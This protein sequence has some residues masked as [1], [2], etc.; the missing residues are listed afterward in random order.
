MIVPEK[1]ILLTSNIYEDMRSKAVEEFINGKVF[2]YHIINVDEKQISNTTLTNW[3]YTIVKYG[4]KHN[5]NFMDNVDKINKLHI[6]KQ[7]KLNIRN[8]RAQKSSGRYKK[9]NNL[10]RRFNAKAIFCFNTT[11]LYL[12]VKARE[13]FNFDTK[14]VAYFDTFTFDKNA[15]V[16]NADKYV[17]ENQSFKDE[18]I[19]R[20]INACDIEVIKFPVPQ[21]INITESM[22]E[23]KD[24]FE[25]DDKPAIMVYGGS[26]GDS[27]IVDI[28]NMF[29]DIKDKFNMVVYCGDNEKLYAKLN[30]IKAEKSLDNFKLYTTINNLEK[31]YMAM[32]CV[33][34]IYDTKAIYVAKLYDKP[35]IVFAPKREVE[36]S[37]LDYL[38]KRESVIYSKDNSDV[39]V[40]TFKV[41]NKD[42]EMPCFNETEIWSSTAKM[43]NYMINTLTANDKIG[44]ITE[45]YKD[46]N[47]KETT[48]STNDDMANDKE[49]E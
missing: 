46:A 17:V 24:M 36:E 42:I 48:I 8:I 13:K 26:H 49:S 7:N 35:I 31:L 25:L 38:S 34:S 41:I 19:K 47:T 3:K 12:A 9:I 10:V 45:P 28:F 40:K 39:I 22:A 43:A 15:T 18:L 4:I 16:L 44:E 27:K 2:G 11:T 6:P 5:I 29:S 1:L 23:C 20:G 14:I 37:D 21:S 30:K 33:I 32:D